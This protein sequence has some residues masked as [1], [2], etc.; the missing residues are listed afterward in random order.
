MLNVGLGL[1]VLRLQRTSLSLHASLHLTCLSVDL[2]HV[3]VTV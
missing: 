2:S 3:R 1:G